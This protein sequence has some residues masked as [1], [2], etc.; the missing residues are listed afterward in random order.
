MRICQRV[1]RLNNPGGVVVF[2]DP[3]Q[4]G[5][6]NRVFRVSRRRRHCE[7]APTREGVNEAR[8]G[9]PQKSLKIMHL[10]P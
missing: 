4:C 1:I 6:V 2:G 5:S 7:P 3:R 9:S 8:S 10:P